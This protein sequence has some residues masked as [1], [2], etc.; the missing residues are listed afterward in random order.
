MLITR[1]I[2]ID[3]LD[4]LSRCQRRRWFSRKYYA[5]VM[6]LKEFYEENIGREFCGI[7]SDFARHCNSKH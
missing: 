3:V 1:I 5:S 2:R 4:C 7:M 6:R